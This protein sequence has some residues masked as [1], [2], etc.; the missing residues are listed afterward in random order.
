M[1]KTTHCRS[2]PPSLLE[3]RSTRQ[4]SNMALPLSLSDSTVITVSVDSWTTCEEAAALAISS[5]G[6]SGDGWSIVLDDAGAV[7]DSNGLDYVFDLVSELELCPAFPVARSQ[8]LKVG[9]RHHSPVEVDHHVSSLARPQV[10]Y[11]Y[12]YIS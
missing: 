4:R 1:Q 2:L 12:S 11:F 10:K 5:S 3:W 9:V 7:T 8:L 6:I